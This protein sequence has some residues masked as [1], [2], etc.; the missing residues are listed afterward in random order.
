MIELVHIGWSAGEFSLHDVNCH[1][2]E[3]TYTV[4]MGQTGCGKT[5]VLEL[6]CG[7]RLPTER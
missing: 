5:T 4:L 3:G 2:P 1:V 6:I 7:L